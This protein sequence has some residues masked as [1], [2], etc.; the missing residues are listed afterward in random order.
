MSSDFERI[1]GEL[2]Y[3]MRRRERLEEK[4]ARTTKK[5]VAAKATEDSLRW[6]LNNLPKDKPKIQASAKKSGGKRG[7]ARG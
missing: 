4:L 5:L 1:E 6:A 7:R 2:T 3:A